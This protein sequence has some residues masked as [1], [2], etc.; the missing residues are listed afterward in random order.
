MQRRVT[1][2]DVARKAG[3]AVS[4]VSRVLNCGYASPAIRAR[5]QS[6]VRQLG[7]VP[8]TNARGLKLGRTGL[9]GFVSWNVFGTWTSGLL[10]GIE[11][12]LVGR[13]L[14]VV[15]A[16]L[17]LRGTFDSS[18]VRAWI[19]ERRVDGLI[20]ARAKEEHT[21]L[22]AALKAS[23]LPTVIVAADRNFGYGV[24]IDSSDEKAGRTA[25][26]HLVQLGHKRIACWSGPK[27]SAAA[28]LR[29]KGVKEALSDHGLTLMHEHSGFASSFHADACVGY[30]KRWLA[31]PKQ[32]RPTGIVMANDEQ[33]MVF[34][35]ML[36]DRGISI[37]EDVSVIGFDGIEQAARFW[38]GVTTVAQPLHAMGSAAA[39]LVLQM[40]EGTESHLPTHVEFDTE[41]IVR[42]STGPAPGGASLNVTQVSEGIVT[43][44]AE[45]E[46]VQIGA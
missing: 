18:A 33:A 40:V 22:I 38:P 29:L 27:E 42:E 8:S 45:P 24:Y 17:G 19:G 34:L 12:E 1:I 16:S 37:V 32:T 30:A 3:V 28:N 36:L 4:T 23:N 11:D 31:L 6:V 35:R 10:G 15:I 21:E 13:S 2:V 46:Q 39:R 26:E 9:L 25:A 20:I 41:L 7:Y 44:I 14:S 5:V 43:A